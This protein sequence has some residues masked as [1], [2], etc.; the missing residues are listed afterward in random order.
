MDADKRCDDTVRR[1]LV[2]EQPVRGHWVRLEEAWRALRANGEYP[3]AVRALLG[4]AVAASVLLAATLKFRGRLTLQMQGHGAVSLLVAQCTHEFGVRAVAHYDEAL[5]AAIDAERAPG[6]RFRAL[7]GEGGRFTVTIEADERNLRYQ[8]I[9]P[10]AGDSLAQSL[11][12]YFSASEQL[13]TSVQL[14]ADEARCAGLLVQKLP[15][16]EAS[17]GVEA[18]WQSVLHGMQHLA[19]EALLDTHVEAVLGS[20]LPERDVRLFNG[21]S[22]TFECR[23]GEGRVTS[24]LRALGADEVREILAEEGAVTVTCE[25]CRRPY[26]FDAQAVEALFTDSGAADVSALIH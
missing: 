26:R 8:G 2:D 25:F 7:V 21:S 1:F 24:L 14:A 15:Q 12:A 9:V 5:A 4:E 3:P 11:E 6:E 17:A 13:P 22:V 23:C 18:L 16:S 19:P 10:L 20:V